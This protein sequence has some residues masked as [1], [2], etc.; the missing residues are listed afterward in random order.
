MRLPL[1]LAL[2]LIGLMLLDKVVM[3]AS[4]LIIYVLCSLFGIKTTLKECK[5][6]YETQVRK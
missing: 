5:E 3:V 1:A 4:T 6:E 2:I